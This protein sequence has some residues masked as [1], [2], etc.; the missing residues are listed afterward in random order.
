MP[1]INAEKVKKT[2]RKRG[3]TRPAIMQAAITLLM[4]EGPEALTTT[5]LSKE[6]GIVQSGFYA[7]FK[8][9]E[10]CLHAVV[11]EIDINVRTPLAEQMAQLRLTDAGDV[12]LLEAFYE[13]VFDRVEENW[14]LMEVFLHLRGDHSIVGRMLSD[15][16]NSLATDLALHLHELRDVNTLERVFDGLSEK[17]FMALSK[18]LLSQSLIGIMQWK[19]GN[20]ERGV[21][22]RLL[23]QQTSKIGASTS[24]AFAM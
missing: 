24:A 4:Q 22:A 21:L 7:H 2:R 17:H 6:V 12:H 18:M 19:T 11:K 23:A 9:I 10:E 13:V 3:Q 16:E 5:R 8:T 14:Q 20:I 15:F 1:E